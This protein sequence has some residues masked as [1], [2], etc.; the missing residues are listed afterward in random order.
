MKSLTFV[1]I[2]RRTRSGRLIP[3]RLAHP[4]LL[5]LFVVV[6]ILTSLLT[7]CTSCRVAGNP[8]SA[9]QSPEKPR[10]SV[11]SPG[12]SSDA[13]LVCPSRAPAMVQPA[14][15]ANAGHRVILSWKASA[16]RNSKHEAAIGYCIYRSKKDRD[17]SPE[18]LNSIPFSGTS[19]ADDW[20]EIDSRYT[21]EVRAISARGIASD[22]SNLVHVAIP[23]SPPRNPTASISS[24]LLCREPAPAK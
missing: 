9:S 8:A 7:A 15:Q 19:C 22:P 13:R 6:S 12:P 2:R 20:V 16:P 23:H 14:L 21:Y 17:S 1:K 10:Q 4:P 5:A 18:L 3:A 24:V 11:I